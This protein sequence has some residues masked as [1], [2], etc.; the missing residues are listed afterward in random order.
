[1][2]FVIY[3]WKKRNT[4]HTTFDYK[5]WRFFTTSPRSLKTVRMIKTLKPKLDPFSDRFAESFTE[6]LQWD[7]YVY[8]RNCP[9]RS[10]RRLYSDELARTQDARS[11][12][13]NSL[14][15]ILALRCWKHE[16]RNLPIESIS[17][18]VQRFPKATH[19]L[20]LR[21]SL[22]MWIEFLPLDVCTLGNSARWYWINLPWNFVEDASFV[23]L[24]LVLFKRHYTLEEPSPPVYI[25]RISSDAI[26]LVS[27]FDNYD[28]RDSTRLL[29][30]IH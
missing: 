8:I 1:M 15:E 26:D 4:H 10:R 12:E 29:A 20:R 23:M 19:V 5:F 16:G 27:F 13:E 24:S 2:Y 17:A 22:P 14:E 6:S 21:R 28:D 25:R 30:V 3:E 7:M 11:R 18:L 9:L